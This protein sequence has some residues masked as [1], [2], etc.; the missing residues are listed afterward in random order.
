MDTLVTITVV[1]DS[2]RQANGAIDAAFAELHRLEKLISFWDKK[3]EIWAIS[4][5]AGV[6]PVKVSPETLDLVQDAL[7]AS[8]MTDGGFDGTIGPVISQWDFHRQIKP[9]DAAIKKA[10]KDVDY[11]QVV[12]DPKNSTVFLKRKGMTFD[13]GGIAKGWGADYAERVL[14]EHGI[15]AG[16]IAIAGDIKAFGRKPD[17]HG[18]LVAI[19][20]PRPLEGHGQ[21]GIFATVELVDQGIS[22]SGD[23]ERYFFKNGVMY[24]HILNPRTGYPARGFESVSIIAPHGYLSDGF[25]TGIFVMGP[26]K[27]IERV[28][29]LERLGFGAVTID[30]N[31]KVFISDNLKGKVNIIKK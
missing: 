23:Y 2:S 9:S 13:T 12:V 7:Y 19:R 30:D 15:K 21:S 29:Q 10:L 31:G 18:W 8:K 3:S 11:R 14:K 24:F 20:D 27:G 22:T 25:S 1:S 26:Q 6:A 16:L 5:K 4:D 28:K 17:G